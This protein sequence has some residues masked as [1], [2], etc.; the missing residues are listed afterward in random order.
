MSRKYFPLFSSKS[1]MASGLLF[2]SLIHFEF[3]FVS[4][5][6]QVMNFILLH[7]N[8]QFSQQHLL[9]RLS[10]PLLSILDSLVKYQLTV[11]VWV[12]FLALNSI[13]QMYLSAFNANTTLF[14][15]YNFTE[16]LEIRDHDASH[17]VLSQEC[18]GYLGSFFQFP[19]KSQNNL[20]QFCENSIGILI[21]IALNVQIALGSMFI[22]NNINNSNH[23]TWVTFPFICIVFDFCHKCHSFQGRGISPACSKVFYC[24]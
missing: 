15:Y 19:Y 4:C 2:K 18:F 7:V 12:Y 23:F 6:S 5:V 3:N 21:E 1:F 10:F 17:F 22:F 13:P 24:F 16:Y 14:D 20:F 9:K 8:I 11:H